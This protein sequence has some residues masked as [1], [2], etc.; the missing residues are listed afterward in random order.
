MSGIPDIEK[1]ESA[2]YRASDTSDHN[3]DNTG[4]LREKY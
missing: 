1:R 2:G 4:Y 3:K